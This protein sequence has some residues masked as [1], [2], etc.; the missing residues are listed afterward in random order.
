MKQNHWTPWLKQEFEQPYFRELATFVHEAYETKT[1]YPPKSQ[2]FSTFETTDYNDIKVVILGQ[3]PYHQPHQA[4]GMCFSVNPGVPLPP[5]LKNI[6]LEL[7]EDVGCTIPDNG[8]LLPWAKQGVF[9]LNTILTV[10][11]SHPLSHAKKGWETFTNHAIEV[12]NQS[13]NPIVFFL[14][15]RQAKKKED[16]IDHQKHCVLTAAHPSP[17]SAYHGFFGCHHFSKANQFLMEQERRPIDWQLPNAEV[18]RNQ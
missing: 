18:Y 9:L 11:E 2:V 10:E 13:S 12:I 16:M 8:Y 7:Q 1:V 3:D 4:H 14:W 6:F 17:L 5:S 15:G